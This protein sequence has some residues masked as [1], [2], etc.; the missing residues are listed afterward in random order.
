MAL[1]INGN[2][3]GMKVSTVSIVDIATNGKFIECA[4]SESDSM[5][6]NVAEKPTKRCG[7]IKTV[8]TP[9]TTISGNAVQAGDLSATQVSAQQLRIWIDNGTLIYFIY[10]NDTDGGTIAAGE[11]TYMAG[12]GYFNSVAGNNG[13]DEISDFDWEFAP[14]GVIDLVP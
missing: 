11:V 14:S 7:V 4:T 2:L 1:S 3:T 10:Q 5:S 8:G 13:V 9:S 6:A 12:S